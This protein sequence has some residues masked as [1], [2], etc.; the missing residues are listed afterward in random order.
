MIKTTTTFHTITGTNITARVLL[1][2]LDDF[3]RILEPKSKTE[4]NYIRKV[5]RTASALNDVIK[6]TDF[7]LNHDKISELSELE[8]TSIETVLFLASGL[9]IK[10]R[11][12]VI[13]YINKLEN[14]TNQN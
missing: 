14:E 9:D 12:M 5:E 4:R 1:P 6:A 8:A 10:K 11:E 2:Y 3:K 13:E 7:L